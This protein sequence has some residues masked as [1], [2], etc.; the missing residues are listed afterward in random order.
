MSNKSQVIINGSSRLRAVG[1][2]YIN[3]VN[4]VPIQCVDLQPTTQ[5]FP[6]TF[7]LTSC[8]VS[9][10]TSVIR[11]GETLTFTFTSTDQ[12][13]TTFTKSITGATATWTSQTS[14]KWQAVV[15]NPT[16]N[17]TITCSFTTPPICLLEDTMVL[18]AD[19]R[20]KKIQEVTYDDLILTYNPYLRRFIGEYPTIITETNDGCTSLIRRIILENGKTLDICWSHTVLIKDNDTYSF[21]PILSGEDENNIIGL[22]IVYYDN[23]NDSM[24]VSK[25]VSCELLLDKLFAKA[26][27]VFVPLHGTIIT[28]DILS[29][30][31]FLFPREAE[32]IYRLLYVDKNRTIANNEVIDLITSRMTCDDE[33]LGYKEV[34]E[35]FSPNISHRLYLSTFFQYTQAVESLGFPISISQEDLAGLDDTLKMWSSCYKPFPAISKVKIGN[36]IYEVEAGQHFTFPGENEKFLDLSSNKVYNSGDQKL[37]HCSIVVLPIE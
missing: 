21:R 22:E 10:N 17:V 14:T 25:V 19:G 13:Y 30:G 18:L 34:K 36:D 32:D 33:I 12:S 37:I 9:P 23:E 20:Q 11:E 31:D 3:S 28:N 6:I 2:A 29:G 24:A 27:N 16:G 1:N 4:G 35:K 7:N 5:Q 26:Y 8:T 15:T